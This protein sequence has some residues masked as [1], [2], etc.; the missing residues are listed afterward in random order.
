MLPTHKRARP[1]DVLGRPVA[2]VHQGGEVLVADDVLDDRQRAHAAGQQRTADR[3]ALAVDVAVAA[4][5]RAREERVGPG[6]AGRAARRRKRLA[7]DMHRIART[8]AAATGLHTQ[9]AHGGDHAGE[10]R[11]SP[12]RETKPA[13]S[14]E[15]ELVEDSPPASRATSIA[16]STIRRHPGRAASESAA[17]SIDDNCRPESD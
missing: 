8:A 9:G 4:P 17:Q 11:R 12:G 6:A 10:V 16:V 1:A 2:R 15:A 3:D 5:A 13:A 7:G 14:V